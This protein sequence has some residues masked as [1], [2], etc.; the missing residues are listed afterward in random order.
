MKI[1]IIHKCYVSYL[2]KGVYLNFRE[3]RLTENENFREGEGILQ[4]VIS[5]AAENQH[6]QLTCLI[7]LFLLYHAWID[8]RIK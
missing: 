2:L 1:C 3:I 5:A 6:L 4:R 7:F 8:L